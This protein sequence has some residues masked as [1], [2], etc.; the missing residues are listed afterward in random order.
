[1]NYKLQI[2]NNNKAQPS[3]MLCL[4]SAGLLVFSGRSLGTKETSYLG[5]RPGPIRRNQSFLETGPGIYC[6][7][8]GIDK[9]RYPFISIILIAEW[10]PATAKNAAPE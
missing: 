7:K 5:V 2:T 10:A 4:F 3:W 1:M 8:R 6:K 9:I